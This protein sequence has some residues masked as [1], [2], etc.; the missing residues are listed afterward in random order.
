MIDEIYIYINA[1]D[2]YN[3]YCQ[4][5]GKYD[6]VKKGYCYGECIRTQKSNTLTKKI[7]AVLFLMK[8]CI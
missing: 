8:I 7:N 1:A 5:S 4:Q 3:T 6:D 2:I